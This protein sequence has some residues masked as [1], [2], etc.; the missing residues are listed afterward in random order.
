M[1]TLDERYSDLLDAEHDPDLVRL[2]AQLDTMRHGTPSPRADMMIRHALAAHAGERTRAVVNH[3]VAPHTLP[4]P[5]L[6]KAGHARL[7]RLGVTGPGQ[8]SH[9]LHARLSVP[10]AALVVLMLG[11]GTYLHGQSPT[12]VSAQTILRQAATAGLAPNQITKFVY[13]VTNSAN[14]GGSVQIWVGASANGQPARL[15]Y[16][17]QPQYDAATHQEV[18]P[19]TAQCYGDIATRFLV[20]SYEDIVGQSSPPSLAGSQVTGQQT[21]DG[22]LC[23]VV[24]APSGATLY[25]DAQ[26]YMLRGAE[27]TDLQQGG[28][29]HGPNSTWH[30]QLSS[31]GTVAASDAPALPWMIET[32]GFTSTTG[33]DAKSVSVTVTR[34]P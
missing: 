20:G 9:R 31:Y 6:G 7:P 27:W 17:P 4:S 8:W 24:Q 25:F 30:A 23:D 13:Q 26:T 22:V 28:A 15:G 21:F 18:C 11:L 5:A 32:N 10:I 29:Q 12:P 14:F 2:V 33:G 34:S 3:P 19:T 16:E 1:T